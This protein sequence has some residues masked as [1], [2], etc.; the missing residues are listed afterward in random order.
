VSALFL[1]DQTKRPIR[2]TNSRP[3]F[4]YHTTTSILVGTEEKRF[5]IHNA[6]ICPR[7]KFFRAACSERCSES[8]IIRLPEVSADDF[9][10]YAHWVYNSTIDVGVED[11][12]ETQDNCLRMYILG[13]VLDD[14][15]LRNAAMELLIDS[16]TSTTQPSP[17]TVWDVYER[18]PE[19]SPLR[20]LLVDWRIGSGE[21]ERDKFAVEVE[22]YPA[23]FVQELA[24]ALMR[25]SPIASSEAIVASLKSSFHPE[26]GI[27]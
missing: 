21:G 18:T 3:S 16:L 15:R 8:K 23:E 13:D 11:V 26:T 4:D 19:G 6:F 14:Y 1:F 24:V 12:E 9:R 25:R 10:L 17:E 2:R 7:S 22:L 27:F 5:I 20:K